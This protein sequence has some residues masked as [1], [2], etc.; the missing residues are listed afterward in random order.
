MPQMLKERRRR[1]MAAPLRINWSGRGHEYAEEDIAVVTEVM[2]KADPLT[3]GQYLK[4]FER[5]FAAHL[6]GGLACFGMTNCAHTLEMAAI[7]SRLGPGD[8]VVVPAHTYCASAIPFAR[9]GATLRWADI[10]RDTFLVSART[11][12]RLVSPRTKVVVVVHLY[13]MLIPDIAA[14][15]D[16]A[17]SRGIIL[18]EDCAQSLGATLG[19]RA[20]GTFGDFGCYSFH[21]QKNITTLG[22]GGML[23][24]GDPD[25]AR[26]VPGLRHNGHAPF[27]GQEEYWRPAM[28]NVVTDIPGVWPHNYSLSEAQAALGSALLRRLPEL[29]VRRRERARRFRAAT[30]LYTEL[31]FQQVDE[32]ESHSHHLMVARYEPPR[33]GVSRDDLIR[34]LS[35][36]YGIK[37]IVQYY[38]L[39]RYDLFRD[40]GFGDADCPETDRFFDAMVSFPAHIG[41]TED[42]FEYLVDST[43]AALK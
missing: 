5:D 15:A 13:G 41:M 4:A 3:Q 39:Y 11:I 23:A 31:A 36:D 14:I 30:A 22:E 2:R 42:E 17:R 28:T 35:C 34:L 6:G 16:L 33:R 8:E 18:V 1:V 37:A 19:G 21:A 32:P 27:T 12:G 40:A 25:R 38:P 24:V 20:G 29:T 9:T 7:L 43:V 26:L 10:E